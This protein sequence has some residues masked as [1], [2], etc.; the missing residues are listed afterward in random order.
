MVSFMQ[1][2]PGNMKAILKIF[3]KLMTIF[4]SYNE[5]HDTY[6]SIT[7]VLDSEQHDS[8]ISLAHNIF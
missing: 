5:D 6:L 2:G 7:A 3:R 8:S 1:Q 4:A